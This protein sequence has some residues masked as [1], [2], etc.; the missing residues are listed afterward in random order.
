MHSDI[1]KAIELIDQRIAALQNIRT[2]LIREFGE[3]EREEVRPVSL[4][5]NTFQPPA[6]RNNGGGRLNRKAQVAD[7]IC[8][9]G[10]SATRSEI[11]NGMGIPAVTVAYCLNDQTLFQNHNGRWRGVENKQ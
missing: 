8:S 10:G 1:A 7:F 11:I 9:H 6:H 3:P 5:P 2:Q 4:K